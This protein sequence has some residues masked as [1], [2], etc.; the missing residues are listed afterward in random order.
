MKSIKTDTSTVF[1]YYVVYIYTIY[2]ICRNLELDCAVIVIR[3]IEII[4][5]CLL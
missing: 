3:L 1:I 2:V 4:V 5:L